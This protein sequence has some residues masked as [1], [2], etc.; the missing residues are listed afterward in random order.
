MQNQN[1]RRAGAPSG[2]AA[3]VVNSSGPSRTCARAGSVRM[4][5]TCQT[6]T[7]NNILSKPLTDPACVRAYA[8]GAFRR[9]IVEVWRERVF[10]GTAEDP[11]RFAVEEAMRSFPGNTDFEL[12]AW[13]ANRIGVSNFANLYFEQLSGMRH[14][15]L[16]NPAAAFHKRLK[17]FYAAMLEAEAAKH[18][19]RKGGAR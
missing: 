3:E 6:H 7:G 15:T 19:A 2:T 10:G 13:Y 4:V 9:E 17:R 1:T 11:V 16:V 14:R 12:W 18:G 8:R 5:H